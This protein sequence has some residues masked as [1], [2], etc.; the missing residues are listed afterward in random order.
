VPSAIHVRIVA[1]VR[2]SSS[3]ISATVSQGS[4]ESEFAALA[5][6]E[7]YGDWVVGSDT[8]RDADPTWPKVGSRFHHRIGFGLLKVSDHTEVLEVDPPYRLV[9]RAKARPLGTANVSMLLT[10]CDGETDVTMIE[11]AGDRLTRLALNRLTD[12]L[13][14]VRNAEALRRLKRIVETGR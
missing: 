9:I 13:I 4:D 11:V 10:E 3:A 12:P 8:I 7:N 14:H 5:N 6:P 1:A 2:R